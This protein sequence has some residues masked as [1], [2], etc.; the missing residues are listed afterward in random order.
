MKTI[1]ILVLVALI[2]RFSASAQT[3]ALKPLEIGDPVPNVTIERLMD[4]PRAAVRLESLK[5]KAVILDFCNTSC[6]AC[7]EDMPHL[8]NL[9]KQFRGKLEVIRI[10]RGSGEKQRELYAR[11][12][13]AA[14]SKLPVAVSDTV[15]SRLFPIKLPHQAWI[16][17]KGVLRAI[18]DSRNATAENIGSL[19]DGG[20]VNVHPFAYLESFDSTKPLFQNNGLDLN[21]HL[22][23]YSMVTG[24]VNG[25]PDFAG[26]SVDEA[27]GAVYRRSFYNRP[28]LWLLRVAYGGL[29]HNRFGPLNDDRRVILAVKDSARFVRPKDK[30]QIVPWE[31]QHTWCYEIQVDPSN[32]SRIPQLMQA[33]LCSYFGFDVA[34]ET[35]KVRGLALVRY[36]SEIKIKTAGKRSIP[37]YNTVAKEYHA[38][39]QKV[40]ALAGTLSYMLPML[41]AD[42]TKLTENIDYTIPETDDP[43]KLRPTLRAFGL[44]LVEKEIEVE[45]LVIR[46]R[47]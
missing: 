45:M 7:T 46:D 6:S 3:L 47:K 11:S 4:Y 19:V 41:V 29:D 24:Y 20:V 35:R 9:K 27:T 2:A 30:N 33:D 1:K 5:G 32:A 12:E 40:D 26:S 38:D 14:K 15:F 42:E 18:T 44:D 22:P 43:E 34:V 28:I 17:R 13:I 37:S 39:N 23:Q 8:M 16:D 21:Q 31:W 36:G 10:T 25:I